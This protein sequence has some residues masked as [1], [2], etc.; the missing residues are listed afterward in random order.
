MAASVTTLS[1]AGVSPG[2]LFNPVPK[3]TTIQVTVA[4]GSSGSATFVQYTLDDPTVPGTTITWANLSSAIV[5]SNTDAVG[6][7][8][9]VGSG[10][11]TYTMLSPIGGLRLSSSGTVTGTVTRTFGHLPF[12]ETWYETGTAIKWKFTSYERDAESGLDYSIFR[13]DSSRLGRFMT[14]DPLAGSAADPQSLNRY[15]YVGNNPANFIDPL[16]LGVCPFLAPEQVDNCGGGEGG[17][18]GGGGGYVDGSWT[19]GSLFSPSVGGSIPTW[20]PVWVPY[21][22]SGVYVDGEF[23]VNATTGYWTVGFLG[24]SS[25]TTGSGSGGDSVYLFSGLRFFKTKH[26]LVDSGPLN[27]NFRQ[28]PENSPIDEMLKA[29][30]EKA[31]KVADTLEVLMESIKNL[32]SGGTF[33]DIPLFMVNI[34]ITNPYYPSC[35]S[36][37]SSSF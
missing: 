11:V 22:N 26:P 28:P 3:S 13:Y 2:V 10:G 30:K 23:T 33:V 37:Q 24:F 25:G 18:A 20:G 32:G 4:S 12:G 27:K 17:D 34:C 35:S 29:M 9:S 8:S 31:E 16:G 19:I 14:R 15:S 1:S 7:G 5:S 6:S 21:S 36:R